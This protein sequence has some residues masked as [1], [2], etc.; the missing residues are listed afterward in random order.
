MK[1]LKV[2]R[3]YPTENILEKDSAIGSGSMS[4]SQL[5]LDGNNDTRFQSTL[6]MNPFWYARLQ[7]GKRGIKWLDVT[8]DAGEYM[9]YGY[10][11]VK[12]F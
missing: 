9:K 6:Q 10:L 1:Q 11:N 5:A 7:G 3:S 12:S 8:V 4:G 2:F